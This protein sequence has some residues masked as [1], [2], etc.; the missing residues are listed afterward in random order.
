MPDDQV[1]WGRTPIHYFW[2]HEE[3]STL[4]LSV[5][6]DLR[7]TV[8]APTGTPHSVIRERVLAR[9]AWILRARR[10]FALYLPAPSPCR[11]VAGES[12]RYLG[13]LYRLR[14][15]R[16]KHSDVSA[17]RG[18]LLV[19]TPHGT[20]VREIRHLVEAWYQER[21][22]VVLPRRLEAMA[23]RVLLVGEPVGKVR[24]RP[25]VRRWGSCS[26]GGLITLNRDL[27][28]APT[29]CIDYVIAHELCHLR[30]HHHGPRFWGLLTR[31]MPDWEERRVRLNK[32]LCQ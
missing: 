13:R 2:R 29:D 4:A 10:E 9:G 5:H 14:I 22:E 20:T 15:V 26:V 21:A 1:E 17:S 3:R 25:L 31:V 19:R 6:P 23:R 32:A 24:I 16:R 12:H 7:I 18:T 8:A 11:Y 28:R 30:E 27:V